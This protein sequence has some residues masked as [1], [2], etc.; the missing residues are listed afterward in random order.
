[1][2]KNVMRDK[3]IFGLLPVLFLGIVP[4]G[5]IPLRGTSSPQSK[6]DAE[7]KESYRATVIDTYGN[8]YDLDHVTISNK[9]N[10]I[11]L[12]AK[13]TQAAALSNKD[14]N[15][16]KDNIPSN[17][18]AALMRDLDPGKDYELVN[19]KD[20][21]SITTIDPTQV[22]TFRQVGRHDDKKPVYDTYLEIEVIF[23]GTPKKE[24]Y[25]V[26]TAREIVGKKPGRSSNVHL[27]I[28]ALKSM[29]MHVHD[30]HSDCTAAKELLETLESGNNDSLDEK[31]RGSLSRMT[32]KLKD[33]IT[34]WCN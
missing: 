22:L 19:L 10:N 14:L 9:E 5:I 25:I 8:V 27:Q 12:Y 33:W 11:I 31:S 20:I 24:R 34:S 28:S 3:S 16:K 13:P 7:K 30:G 1:M 2:N 6:D 18:V 32:K 23:R 4:L 26:Q 29:T 17:E 15:L 21:A